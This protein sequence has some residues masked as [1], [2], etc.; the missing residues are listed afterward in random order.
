MN[1]RKEIIE[2][3]YFLKKQAFSVSD[4]KNITVLDNV[5][6]ESFDFIITSAIAKLKEDGGMWE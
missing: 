3:L 5:Y 4:K 1:D 6:Y 2:M